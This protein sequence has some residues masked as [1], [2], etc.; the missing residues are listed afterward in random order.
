MNM[1][2]CILHMGFQGDASGKESASA[3]DPRQRF[4]S[5][6]EDPWGRKRQ[7]VPVFL[8]GKPRRGALEGFGPCSHRENQIQLSD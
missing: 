5:G 1:Y 6:R 8:P 2:V 3:G 7:S 4:N